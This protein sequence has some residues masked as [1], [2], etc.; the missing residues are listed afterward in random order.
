MAVDVVIEIV[1]DT[2]GYTASVYGTTAAL[3]SFNYNA[4]KAAVVRIDDPG[5]GRLPELQEQLKGS[6]R[7]RPLSAHEAPDRERGRARPFT[8]TAHQR[9][10]SARPGCTSR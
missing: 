10:R 4:A 5:G 1:I 8:A 9:S 6:R 3:G 2:V 7:C